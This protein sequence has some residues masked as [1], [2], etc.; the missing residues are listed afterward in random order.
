MLT[1]MWP[2]RQWF[3]TCFEPLHIDDLYHK[4]SSS[5]RPVQSSR[6]AD[7]KSGQTRE[8]TSPPAQGATEPVPH[9]E[10]QQ[11]S[12]ELVAQMRASI[13]EALEAERVDISDT[14][15]DGRHVSIDVVSRL[16]EGQSAVKRQRMV[17][18]LDFS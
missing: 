8:R 6:P 11:V 15:G 13:A 12:A 4:L 2:P 3:S 1:T 18:L 10:Q 5:G 17:L 16:F 9:V 7:E 14:Y